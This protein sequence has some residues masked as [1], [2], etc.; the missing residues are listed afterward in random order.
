MYFFRKVGFDI[1]AVVQQDIWSAKYHASI[2]F[3]KLLCSFVAEQSHAIGNKTNTKKEWS[4]PLLQLSQMYGLIQGASQNSN[5]NN[6]FLM[7]FQN[8]K[9]TLKHSFIIIPKTLATIT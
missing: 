1:P 9:I 6:L 5:W 8:N 4:Y 7:E 3:L 2:M